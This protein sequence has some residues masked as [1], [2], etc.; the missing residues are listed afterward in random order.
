MDGVE[1]CCRIALLTSILSKYYIY[2]SCILSCLQSLQ[3]GGYQIPLYFQTPLPYFSLGLTKLPLRSLKV[4]K[5]TW[6][7]KLPYLPYSTSL[8][9]YNLS[10]PDSSISHLQACDYSR[11]HPKSH[12]NMDSAI[13]GCPSLP[14][15]SSLI[16]VL[17]LCKHLRLLHRV[18]YSVGCSKLRV[19][20]CVSTRTC[21]T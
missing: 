2:T 13:Q 3:N 21:S 7:T 1:L 8:P 17:L 10:S 11:T 6:S 12:M 18:Y 19:S 9:Y 14:T 15:P 20:A 4:L 16:L 5:G